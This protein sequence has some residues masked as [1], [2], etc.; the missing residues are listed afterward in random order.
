MNPVELTGKQIKRM[1]V[2][3][4]RKSITRNLKEENDRAK[5]VPPEYVL[6]GVCRRSPRVNK[7]NT[8]SRV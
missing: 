3:S 2:E 6:P 1:K 7:T 5:L 8:N 4:T